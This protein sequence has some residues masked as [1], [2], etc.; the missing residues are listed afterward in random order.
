MIRTAIFFF[1]VIL[2]TCCHHRGVFRQ[3]LAMAD[4]LM[5][6]DADSAY[7]LLCRMDLEATRMPEWLRMEHLLLKCNAQNKADLLFSSD[8][9]GLEL[10]E[11]YDRKGNNNQRMLAHYI[12]GCA[13]RDVK[14]FPSALQ[15]F[16]DAVAA[17]DT[18]ATDCDIYQMSII[19]GQ[20]GD[21]YINCT[22]PEKVIDALDNCEYYSRL[23]DHQL[24]IYSSLV[25]KGKALIS[26]GK[27]KEALDLNDKAVKGLDSLGYHWYATAARFQCVE[28]LMRDRQM[29]K[30]KRYLDDYE[31]NSGY[32]LPNGDIEEGREDY[33]Y[34]KGTYYL[35]SESLD[36][37]EYFFRKLMR[38]G[39]LMNDKY[40]A[41]WG[42]S[43]LYKERGVSDS[44]AKY[45]YMGDVLGDTLYDE[46]VAQIMLQNQAMFDYSRYEV[47]AA[48]KEN[49]AMRAR[50]RLSI[51]YV[52]CGLA[53]VAIGVIIY[54]YVRKNRQLQQS[55]DMMLRTTGRMEA[56]EDTHREYLDKLQEKMQEIARLEKEV[57]GEKEAGEALRHELEQMKAA[58]EQKKSEDEG[59]TKETDGQRAQ[60]RLSEQVAVKRIFKLSE[61]RQRG[62]REEEWAE[63]IKAVEEQYP[64]LAQLKV[65]GKLDS[66]EY[67]VCVLVKLGMKV[68]DI[69]FLTEST[70]NKISMMRSRLHQKLFGEKGGAK[71]FDQRMAEL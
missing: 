70:S 25:L 49:E 40:L 31:A 19:Y 69:I 51:L 57:A 52:V 26:E 68:N 8:S 59:K 16:N 5:R 66:L 42:L 58:A 10:V 62:P 63:C 11:Y 24:G 9:I 22:L 23:S 3:Q 61:K 50:W 39:T 64:R 21:I 71:D 47:V 14:D 36:S 37:A 33:Y 45:A 12:L 13:Y 35:L 55:S 43:Q 38:K 15:C 60:R 7:R 65:A 54:K 46:K 20:I 1:A 17:A 27:I 28:W 53:M 67:R 4:T 2:L 18:N 34:S 41:A 44:V 48:K 56:L 29:E 30:A 6:T 32:F